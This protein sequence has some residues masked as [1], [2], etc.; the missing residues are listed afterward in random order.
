MIAKPL[1][2]LTKKGQFMWSSEA[3][4]AFDQLKMAMTTVPV[5]RLPDF[6][7]TF[8]VETDACYGGLGAVLSQENHPIAFISKALGTKN[9]GLSIYEKEFLA[10]L[11]AIDK[12]RSYLLHGH[13]IIKTDQQS[14]KYLLEQKIFTP[15]QHKYLTK[16]LGFDY[17]IEY[18]KGKENVVADALSRKEDLHTQCNVVTLIKPAWVEELQD[19]YLGDP[20]VPQVITESLSFPYNLSLYTYKEGLV[21]YKGK[22]YVSCG[23]DLRR[24]IIAFIHTSALGGHSGAAV[25]YNR[26]YTTFWWP[27]LKQEVFQFVSECHTCQ[28]CKHELVKTPGLLQPLSVPTGPWTDISMD[29]IEKLPRLRGFDTIWVIVDR[30]TKYNHFIALSHPYSASH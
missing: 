12:W 6:S 21:R 18:R 11:L 1:T 7:K 4:S 14:L 3:T 5:L 25:T 26:I 30:F 16:L 28:L 8:V 10:I 17:N 27:T 29:F 23:V 9:L 13:F 19:S 20:I 15:R 24:K 22:L 2:Q